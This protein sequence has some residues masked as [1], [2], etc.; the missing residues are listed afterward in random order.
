MAEIVKT[1]LQDCISAACGLPRDPIQEDVRDLALA[2][3]NDKAEM[4]W[5]KWPWDNEK[6]D[7]FTAPTADS[8]GIITFAADVESIRAMKGLDSQGEGTRIWNEDE[9]IAAAQGESVSEDRFQHLSDSSDGYRRILLPTDAEYASYRVL[10][11]KRFTRATVEDDYDDTDPT[12]TPT[13]Y[14]VQRWILERAQPAI[15]AYVK[16]ALRVFMGI[17]RVGDGDDLLN[18][19]L[20]RETY[21]ADRERRVNPRYPQF[22][23]VGNW[24]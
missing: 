2:E 13:D 8:D 4:I 5:L 12:A 23:E 18:V 3:F 1:I 11:L 20:R 15:R 24:W 10:A 19:A 7:E 16:D 22:S 6:M 9:L 21:D 17:S 14:R